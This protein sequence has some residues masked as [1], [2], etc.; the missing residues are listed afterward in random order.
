MEHN[1]SDR[2]DDLDQAV[3]LVSQWRSKWERYGCGYWCMREPPDQAVMGYCGVKTVRFRNQQAL[4]LIYRLTPPAW[5]RGL[6]TEAASVVVA[7]AVK[8]VPDRRII[9]RVRPDN[10]SSQRVA[11]KAAQSARPPHVSVPRPARAHLD[12]TSRSQLGRLLTLVDDP[13]L[14]TSITAF[15]APG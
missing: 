6:A 10:Q 12:P 4:S 7:W 2:L 5:G 11:M 13:E 9:A 1:P 8:H 15:V 14:E 3:D